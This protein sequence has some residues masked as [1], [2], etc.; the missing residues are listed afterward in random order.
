MFK[1]IKITAEVMKR[2]AELTKKGYTTEECQ[3]ISSEIVEELKKFDKLN[4][5]EALKVIDEL[6]KNY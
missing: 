4:F 2:V 6:F 5:N 3:N 1:K